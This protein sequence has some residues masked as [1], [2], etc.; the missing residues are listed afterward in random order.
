MARYSKRLKLSECAFVEPPAFAGHS[1][2]HTEAIRAGH[3]HER[4]TRTRLD[5]EGVEY[6]Y[7][8]WIGY[9]TVDGKSGVL[10]PDFIVFDY[11]RLR[12]TILEAK[13]SH[14]P[15]AYFQ[16]VNAYAPCLKF[17]FPLWEIRLQEVVHWYDAFLAFPGE[18]ALRRKLTDA[19]P[20][21]TVGVHILR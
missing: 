2:G 12:I 4:K 16:L 18:H 7:G 10:Q 15:L 20:A 9:V 14:T 5:K 1:T 11:S 8:C 3:R 21:P 17:M 19:P 6:L 13:L